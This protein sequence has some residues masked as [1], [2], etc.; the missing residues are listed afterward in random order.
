MMKLRLGLAA[1]PGLTLQRLGVQ[2]FDPRYGGRWNAGSNKRGGGTDIPP[3]R[4]AQLVAD[5]L[6]SIVDVA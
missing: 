5:R 2:A 4:Y 3:E 1:P 6:Q